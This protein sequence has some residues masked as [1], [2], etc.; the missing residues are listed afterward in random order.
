LDKRKFI[1]LAGAAAAVGAVGATGAARGEPA[2]VY[3][4]RM[5]TSWVQ[6]TPLLE[7]CAL[8]FAENVKKMSAGRLDIQV[9][10]ANKHKSPL[11][12]FDFVRS[13][14]AYEMGHTAS[15]YYKGKDP[16]T[17][18]FTTVPFGLTGYE[19]N[20]WFYYGGG[21]AMMQKVYAKH[22]IA[23]FNVGNTQVQMGGWFR[24]EIKSLADLKGLKMRIPGLAGEVMEKVGV[25]PVSIP[26]GELYTALERG[27]IDAV[28]WIN[29]YNDLKMGFQRI[30]KFYYTG[31][32]EP[33]AEIQVMVN[34]A[35][36]D[37]LPDDLKAIIAV[38]AKEASMDM[39]AESVYMNSQDWEVLVKEDKIQVKT[40]PPDVIAAL[41]KATQEALAEL[42]AKSG[43]C[44]EIIAS[45]TA[46]L[47]KAREWT[48][49]SEGAYL[50]TR[51]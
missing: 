15:Y 3:K 24:K 8:R 38:A 10:A 21:L 2:Q 22:G 27:T 47:A 18:L 7:H 46:Y 36:F 40:F 35:K 50:V 49:H 41:K 37:A 11:G 48:R 32:H 43:E 44:R 4:W 34:K 19:Q 28:E 31:W 1:G 17:T 39:M 16:A 33:G 26:G 20:G 5:A 51:G 12:I 23:I 42:A 45:Q 29:P 9:D 25:T 6:G 30:A 14:D 13:G